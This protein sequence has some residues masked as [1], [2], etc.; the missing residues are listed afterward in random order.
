MPLPPSTRSGLPRRRACALYGVAGTR[1]GARVRGLQN[2][3]IRHL[4][5]DFN[6]IKKIHFIG[7]GGIGVSA[8]AKYFLHQGSKVSGSDVHQSDLTEELENRGV[9]VFYNHNEINVPADAQLVI[10]S[11]AVPPEN[12]ERAKAEE[13]G[14]LTL[15]YPEF[16]GRF[17]ANKKTIAIAGTN[18]KSTTTAMIGSIMA[19]AGLDP[20]VIVGTLTPGF[21]GNLRVGKTDWLVVEACEWKAHMLNLSPQIIVLTDLVPDHLDFYKNIDDLKR[22]FQQF[23]DKLPLEKGLL[24]FNADDENLRNLVKEKGYEV[25]N[26]GVLNKEV[27]NLAEEIKV[28]NREQI[29]K[30][31]KTIFKLVIP[32]VY[33]V[34]NALA[35]ITV[36]RYLKIKD[37]VTA[38]A[39]G[40]FKGSW[41][42]FELLG[43]L[44]GCK[45]VLVIS[46][47]AH[48][49]KALKG[50]LKAAKEFYP[51]R[52]LVAVFQPHHYDRTFKLF[53]EFK[54]SFHG[55]DLVIV[56]EIYDVAGREKDGERQVSSAD[57]VEAIKK[58]I[59]AKEVVYS[60]DLNETGEIIK[61]EV[62]AGDLVLMIG[63][64]DID[65][66][67]RKL[68]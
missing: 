9:R 53:N 7:L 64:G 2:L 40:E 57:L 17:S 60:A 43:G 67:A 14:V 34:Y 5:M 41:R 21:D 15:S 22:H 46:D 51:E 25:L 50:V 19:E 33:N 47:Y 26:W 29:F 1:S 42:R 44:K 66:L 65:E 58:A 35:A 54:E 4:Y 62:K 45:D 52:R 8:I 6:K 31:D 16:L 30:S 55:A 23:I 61:K 27:N 56:N 59:P 24:A 38:K 11:P 18:G 49:P 10:Y 68:I 63:A 20:T 48:H 3:F 12:P 36:A 37:E 32:G 39:L 13:M 28:E